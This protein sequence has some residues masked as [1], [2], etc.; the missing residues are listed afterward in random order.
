MGVSH[1]PFQFRPWNQCGNGIDYDQIDRTAPNKSFGNFKSLFS[2]I[3]LRDKKLF[4]FNAEFSGV[5]DIKRM[6]SIDKSGC[7]PNFL[8]FCNAMEG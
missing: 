2:G 4:R 3:G 5:R 1:F 7:S 6:F 8:N